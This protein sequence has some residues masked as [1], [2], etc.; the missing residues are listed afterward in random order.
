MS[1]GFQVSGDSLRAFAKGLD[2]RSNGIRSAADAVGSV[3]FGVS[4]FGLVGQ[5]FS[6]ACRVS[7]N[8]TKGTLTGAATN[9]T[10]AADTARSTAA[11]YEQHD[12]QNSLLF[13]G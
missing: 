7:C 12:Q 5:V 4:A 6:I 9:V 10:S 2:D 11:T 3:N 8:N 13:K 1:D